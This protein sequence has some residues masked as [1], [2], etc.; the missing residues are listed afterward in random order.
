MNEGENI[1]EV[2]TL[3]VQL[4]EL[5][6]RSQV[7]LAQFWQVPLAYLGTIIIIV[8]IKAN[9]LSKDIIV[10]IYFMSFIVGTLIFWHMLN[11]VD[12]NKRATRN[13]IAI[14][15]ALLLDKVKD[16]RLAEIAPWGYWL[17]LL[18]I[19]ICAVIVSAILLFKNLNISV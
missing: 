16:H 13:I 6:R 2:S 4:Q 14:E 11:I 8:S 9:E 18:L 12:W 3:Q 10:F 17:P 1:V 15:R 7:Y 19:V 5:N